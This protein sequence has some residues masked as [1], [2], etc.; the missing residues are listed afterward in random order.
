MRRRRVAVAMSGGVDSS[1]AAW[2]LLR[3]GFGVEGFTLRLSE[4]SSA[5]SCCS[6]EGVVRAAEV[7]RR[8]GIRHTVLSVTDLFEEKVV[9]PFV[10]AYGLGL[11]PNPCILCNREVK[12]GY[13]LERVLALGFD[14]L[15]TG[16]YARVERTLGGVR[17]RMALDREKDQSYFL[18]GVSAESLRRLVLPLGSMKKAEVVRTAARL[19]LVPGEQRESQDVCFVEPGG[20]EAFLRSRLPAEA[21]E[22]GEIVDFE[23]R[24]L[25]RHRGV[26][27][28]TVGQRKGLGV[29][30]ERPLYVRRIEPEGRRLVVG[31]EEEGTVRRFFVRQVN[32]VGRPEEGRMKVRIRSRSGL[33]S[34]CVRLEGGGRAL[35]ELERDRIAVPAGQ[36]AVFYRGDRLVGGGE[37]ERP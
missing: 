8:L 19:G 1:F 2:W 18:A 7:C 15:A 35:V 11:T 31:A 5:R 26:A 6:A 4:V 30:A 36:W 21:T 3:R 27:F 25:G 17:L 28:Y 12:F 13:L 32:F 34:C 22:P 33:M 24:V 9:V 16:H 20:L 37:M 29:T 23:G 14:A 10:E